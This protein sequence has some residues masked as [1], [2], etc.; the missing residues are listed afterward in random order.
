MWGFDVSFVASRKKLWNIQ[1]SDFRRHDGHM[2]YSSYVGHNNNN[3]P[4]TSTEAVSLY[5]THDINF[6]PIVAPV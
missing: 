4:S 5:Q 6:R 3:I 2:T 1:S